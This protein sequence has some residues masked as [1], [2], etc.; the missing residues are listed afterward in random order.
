ME[1]SYQILLTN[2]DGIQSPGLWA[3]AEALSELGYVHVVAPRDQFSGAG[4]SLPST[5]DGIITPQQMQ[6]GGKLWTVY[7]VGGT[8]AQSVLH[9]ICEILPARPDLVVSGINY[10]ENLG[11]GITVSGT[12]GAAM[13]G[14]GNGI[15][16]LAVSLE[17]DQKDHLSYSTE[18]DF[19][20][21]AYFT[22]L[23]GRWMLSK[24]LPRDVD[25]LKVDV[26]CEARLDTAWEVTRLSKHRYFEPVTPKRSVWDKPE[27]VGYRR[28]E[29]VDRDEL[30]TDV[31]ALRVK[32]VV[33]VTPLSLDMTSRLELQDFDRLLRAG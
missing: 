13:E 7:S 18:I 8:P 27:T 11:V 4:R 24:P 16:S 9:A 17:T 12:V 5:S 23:F 10:G 31:Y 1:R 6:V 25:L 21:A 2:D 19:S 28:I 22:Q 14:A 15:P 3:A 20:A 32:R 29:Q 26:P 30:D 33:A